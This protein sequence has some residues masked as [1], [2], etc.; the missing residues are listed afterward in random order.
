MQQR[1]RRQAEAIHGLR[2]DG[3]GLRL[4]VRA[5]G[6]CDGPLRLLLASDKLR[7]HGGRNRR[8]RLGT[9]RFRIRNDGP[10]HLL[11]N[12]VRRRL[13]GVNSAKPPRRFGSAESSS[14]RST[15]TGIS[16]TGPTSRAFAVAPPQLGRDLA[17]LLQFFFAGLFSLRLGARFFGA[18]TLKAP[19]LPAVAPCQHKR[20]PHRQPIPRRGKAEGGQQIH[21]R[22]A[23]RKP[24]PP[25]RP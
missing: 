4:G 13:L 2:R 18:G 21:R 15:T 9:G 10:R 1:A 17:F 3:H 7:L 23:P 16:D 5:L 6:D 8:G 25:T 11:P 22:H 19:V 24:Q 14:S 20:E 12:G